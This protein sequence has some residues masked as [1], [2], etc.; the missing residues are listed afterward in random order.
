MALLSVEE[1]GSDASSCFLFMLEYFIL[2][3][4]LLFF[5]KKVSALAGTQ[6]R[7]V[8]TCMGEAMILP[9]I[10]VMREMRESQLSR[11]SYQRE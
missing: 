6:D 3:T 9:Y 2:P 5:K 4:C 10:E 11:C 8:R 1:L 7:I